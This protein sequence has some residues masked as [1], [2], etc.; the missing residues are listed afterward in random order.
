MLILLSVFLVELVI[1]LLDPS[2]FIELVVLLGR[3]QVVFTFFAVMS[4]YNSLFPAQK[5]TITLIPVKLSHI[6]PVSH[7]SLQHVSV[8]IV[9]GGLIIVH[10]CLFMYKAAIQVE[11]MFCLRH[12]GCILRVKCSHYCM[13]RGDD[14]LVLMFQRCMIFLMMSYGNKSVF[15]FSD[16]IYFN[17]IELTTFLDQDRLGL[18]WPSMTFFS[19]LYHQLLLG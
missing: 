17:E 12:G 7:L 11:S 15:T 8:G 4:G 2:S 18:A 19:A 9:F 14:F 3:L 16:F 5:V 13:S 1:L 10:V 6:H